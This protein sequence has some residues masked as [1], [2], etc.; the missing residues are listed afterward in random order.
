ML[1]NSLNTC[2]FS[3]KSTNTNNL[4]QQPDIVLSRQAVSP[5]AR[6]TRSYIMTN[7][8]T[9][10]LGC[11]YPKEALTGIQ[12]KKVLDIGCGGG[13]AVIELREKGVDAIGIDV[14]DPSNALDSDELSPD[15]Y[16]TPEDRKNGIFV[17]TPA[18]Q[19]PFPD[20]SF[21]R[22]LSSLA[23]FFEDY[24]QPDYQ[25]Q[26]LAETKR[27]LKPGGELYTYGR[28][29]Q[30]EQIADQVGGLEVTRLSNERFKIK[31][32]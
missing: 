28:N 22:A 4:N 6:R 5:E 27:V 25:K 1:I 19:T 30:M 23:V 24:E 11:F 20:N 29:A 17:K 3:F 18:H 15:K 13:K 8:G 12:G 9:E 16:L 31:K 26:A 32:L 7:R 21:D 10:T 2:R 14:G